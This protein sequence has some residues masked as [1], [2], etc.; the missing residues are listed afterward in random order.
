MEEP[1]LPGL[2][3][4]Q[5]QLFFINYAQLWCSKYSNEKAEINVKSEKHAPDRQR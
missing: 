3:Y 4:N 5:R 2:N 1:L